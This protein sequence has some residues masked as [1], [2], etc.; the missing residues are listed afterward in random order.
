V[1]ITLTA[2]APP[3]FE[4]IASSI[5]AVSMADMK[6]RLLE[7]AFSILSKEGSAALTTRRVCE[8]VG[9]TM[10]T[11]YHHFPSRDALVQAVHA[12]AMQQFMAKKR[13]LALSEDPLRDLR[14]SCDLVLDFV[15]RNKN[16]TIAV[17]SR[18]LEQPELF[19]PGLEL[20]QERVARAAAAGALR[21]SR[22]DAVALLWTAVQGLALASV[23]HPGSSGL[24]AA[25]RRRLLDAVFSAI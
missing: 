12:E 6:T 4:T 15:A 14:S 8:A 18:A 16:V 7:A 21:G 10:P 1:A 3:R 13:S 23:A 20:L 2:I 25:V 9:V 22:Q 5:V 11:L 17:M 19:R 24:P